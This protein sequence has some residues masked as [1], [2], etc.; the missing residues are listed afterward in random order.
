[1][2]IAKSRILLNVVDKNDIKIYVGFQN[3]LIAI[4]LR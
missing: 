3:A 1:M 2:L 4:F